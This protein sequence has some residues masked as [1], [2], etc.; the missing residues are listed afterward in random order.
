MADTDEENKNIRIGL[1]GHMKCLYRYYMMQCET[2]EAEVKYLR[3]RLRV[4][5]TQLKLSDTAAALI[6]IKLRD[7]GVRGPL[8][9]EK[10]ED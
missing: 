3:E 7:L 5:E 8:T 9:E 2:V 1:I 6:G 4:L 10:D